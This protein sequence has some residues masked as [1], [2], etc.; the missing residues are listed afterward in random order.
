[1]NDELLEDLRAYGA[2]VSALPASMREPVTFE[3]WPEHEDAVLLFLRSQTQWRT[4]SSGVMGLDY[5]AVFQIMDLYDVGDR[6]QTLE[7]L[8]VMESRARE[9]INQEALKAAKATA[10]PTGRK[11]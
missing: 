5:G 2:D 7:D 10:K 1:M 11:G 9:L 6:R 3:V 4:T 8:Q